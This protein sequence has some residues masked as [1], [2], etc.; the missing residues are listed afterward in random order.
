MTTQEGSNRTHTEAF[1]KHRNIHFKELELKNQANT[2]HHD[3]GL[4]RR[5]SRIG[6]SQL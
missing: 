3:R 2:Q 6:G 4:V 1:I 5:G